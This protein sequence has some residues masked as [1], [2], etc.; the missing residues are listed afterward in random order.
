[1]RLIRSALIRWDNDGVTLGFREAIWSPERFMSADPTAKPLHETERT[2]GTAPSGSGTIYAEAG[3][4]EPAIAKLSGCLLTTASEV[5]TGSP[6]VPL[7][8][9]SERRS[10]GVSYYRAALS[11][12]S[13]WDTVRWSVGV[14]IADSVRRPA[15]VRTPALAGVAAHLPAP[16]GQGSRPTE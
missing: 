9:D 13:F 2:M 10:A 12:R 14:H 6:D 11:R 1:M 4:S 7:G 5:R 8:R 15:G 16:R 3:R